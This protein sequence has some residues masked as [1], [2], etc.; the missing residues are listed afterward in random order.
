VPPVAAPVS[1]VEPPAQSVVDWAVLAI[2]VAL[3]VTVT[4]AVAVQCPEAAEASVTV[5]V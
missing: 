3:T 2:S 5:K 4:L 1:W